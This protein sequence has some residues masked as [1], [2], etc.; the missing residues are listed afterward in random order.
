[1]LIVFVFMGKSIRIQMFNMNDPMSSHI[2][3]VTEMSVNMNDF[4]SSHIFQITEMPV[5]MSDSMSSHI[6]ICLYERHYELP[7]CPFY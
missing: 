1:M 6:N 5:N 2:I 3:L 7:Y 4:F